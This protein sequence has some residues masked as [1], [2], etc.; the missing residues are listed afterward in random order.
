MFS[1]FAHSLYNPWEIR[2]RDT[3]EIYLKLRQDF[4]GT[5][6]CSLTLFYTHFTMRQMSHTNSEQLSLPEQQMGEGSVL[7]WCPWSRWEQPA[8][9]GLCV[10][11][12]M[13]AWP[14]VLQWLCDDGDLRHVTPQAQVC[15]TQPGG[16]ESISAHSHSYRLTVFAM[17]YLSP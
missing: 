9:M 16:Q 4:M 7:G 6:P 15:R 10:P 12:R 5:F 3:K 1:I 11:V 17:Q 14:S 8:A 13:H 2:G